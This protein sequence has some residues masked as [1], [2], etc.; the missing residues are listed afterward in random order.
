MNN[1]SILPV[2]VTGLMI[3]A[4]HAAIPT[5]WLPFVIASR[6]QKWSWTKTQ[7]ILLI[8]GLGHVLM[9][10]LLGAIIFVLG[11]EFFEKYANYFLIISSLSIAGFGIYQI[12]QHFRGNKHSHCDHTH[13]HH[14]YDELQKTKQDGWAF[15]SLLSMLTFSP[16]ESFL[17]VYLSVVHRGWVGFAMLSGVLIMGTL[18]SMLLLTWISVKGLAHFKMGWLED[19]EKLISGIVLIILSVLVFVIEFYQH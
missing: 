12:A 15:L 18:S 7:S 19:N 5:H 13:E 8:A 6:T 11:L 2:L 14:H 17:P 1:F 10:T 3:A 16:C 9:T 4:F